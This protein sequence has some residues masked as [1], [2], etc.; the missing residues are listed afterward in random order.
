MCGTQEKTLFVWNEGLSLMVYLV[1]SIM[2][3]SIWHRKNLCVFL[4]HSINNW[5][6]LVSFIPRTH[7]DC[8]DKNL[9][10][11]AS[12]SLSRNTIRQ[13]LSQKGSAWF[14][15]FNA[16]SQFC[17]L[18]VDL[19]LWFIFLIPAQHNTFLLAASQGPLLWLHFANTFT[20]AIIPNLECFL[21]FFKW[22]WDKRIFAAVKILSSSSLF[23]KMCHSY[24]IVYHPDVNE[25]LKYFFENISK[26]CNC[27]PA[28]KVTLVFCSLFSNQG[29]EQ[30]EQRCYECS[31]EHTGIEEFGLSERF[32]LHGG[33]TL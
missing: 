7:S 15:I 31:Y 17:Y 23:N 29:F 19:V 4:F 13:L 30:W 27:T 1:Q 10:L 12:C 9:F 3:S 22:L 25:L 14:S 5:G 21:L 11:L 16:T 32:G 33:R 24:D 28:T 20:L 18:S 6:A 2:F 26:C 8:R